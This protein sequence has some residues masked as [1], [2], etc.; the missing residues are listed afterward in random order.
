MTDKLTVTVSLLTADQEL[1][2]LSWRQSTAAYYQMKSALLT[3]IKA[4][5]GNKR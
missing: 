1:N 2:F 5:I 4:G 3:D